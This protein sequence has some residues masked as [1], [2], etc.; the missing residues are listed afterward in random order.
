MLIQTIF[1]YSGFIV[2]LLLNGLYVKQQSQTMALSG[3]PFKNKDF[4]RSTICMFLFFAVMVGIRYDVGTDHL[5]YWTAYEQG[6]NERFEFLFQLLSNVCKKLGFHPAVFFGLLGLIQ[7]VFFYWAFKDESFLFPLFAVFLFTDGLF[8]SW[9][10]T[11]RQDMACCIW[12]FSFNYIFQKKPIKYLLFC[13]VAFLIHRSA[14]VLVILYPVFRNGKDYIQKMP[15]QIIIILIA[16][17]FRN[18]FGFLLEKLDN[19]F[20]MYISLISFNSDFDY[21]TNYST[22][23]AISSIGQNINDVR[24]TGLGVIVKHISYLCI[25]LF[26]NKVKNY[27][28]SPKL[29]AIYTL[30]FI[31]YIAYIVLPPGVWS[32]SRPFQYLVCTRMIMLSF[33]VYY[34]LNSKQNNYSIIGIII[35]VLHILLLLA[36][37]VVASQS[38]GYHGYQFF[39]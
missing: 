37:N 1:V 2:V 7:I 24:Q 11:I 15:V 20:S 26:S 16:F 5:Y 38:V 36:S 27:Y 21:Y 18:N 14:I 19:L 28:N 25:V 39:F 12:I 22:E 33:L 30:F 17:V 6:G 35:I 4:F 34:L 10:N 3:S 13:F 23:N 8:G 9:M 29:N 32:L 31:S